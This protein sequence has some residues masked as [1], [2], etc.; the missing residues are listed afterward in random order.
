PRWPSGKVSASGPESSRCE[1]RFHGRSAVYVGL[2]HAKSYVGCQTSSRRCNAEVWRVGWLLRYR[3]RHLTPAENDEVRP[4]IA[5]VF[6][7][8]GA[9]I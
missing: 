7:Q 2:L 8:S 4:K 1:T 9:L 5:L 6:L 3:P